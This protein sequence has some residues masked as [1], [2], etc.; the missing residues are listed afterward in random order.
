MHRKHHEV[1]FDLSK[2]SL[3]STFDEK[4]LQATS[5]IEFALRAGDK[6]DGHISSTGNRS[7]QSE[8]VAMVAASGDVA[9]LRMEQKQ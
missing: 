4:L 2:I 6:D 9:G 8:H 5:G 3:I 1:A 7:I